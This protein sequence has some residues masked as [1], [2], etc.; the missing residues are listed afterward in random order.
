MAHANDIHSDFTGQTLL[1]NLAFTKPELIKEVISLSLLNTNG[2]VLE[3]F[4]V[5]QGQGMHSDSLHVL[6]TPSFERFRFQLTGTTTDGFLLRRIKPTEIKIEAVQLDFNYR[7]LNNSRR[8]FPGITTKIPLKITN[9]GNS[10]NFTLKAMDD[11][12]FTKS[13]VPNY[14]FVAENDTAEFSL[15]VTAPANAS[16]GETSTVAVYATPT[17][18]ESPSNYMVFYVS[19]KEMVSVGNES[20]DKEQLVGIFSFHVPRKFI[21]ACRERVLLRQIIY[22]R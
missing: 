22:Y 18:T 4:P 20:D 15:I 3:S 6:F 9:R 17:S 11:F 19:V 16:S 1:L 5:K 13:V 14:C 2:T 10:Q 8:I 7:A 21:V 12:G